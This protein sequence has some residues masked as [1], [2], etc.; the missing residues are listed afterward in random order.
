MSV[1]IDKLYEE[2]LFSQ[3]RV[4]TEKVGGSGTI[5]YSAPSENTKIYSTYVI[6]CHHII[7][8]A[9]SVRKD[10]D[11]KLGREKK[12]EFRQLVTTEFFDWS[13][14][15]HG[16]R[17][18]NYSTDA[19]ILAY[20]KD[21]DMALLKLRTVKTASYVAEILHPDYV[22]GLRVGHPVWA[23]GAALLH[24]PILTDGIITHMGDDIDF[25]YYWMSNAPIIF[26]NSGGAVFAETSNGY[27]FIGIPS[28]VAIVGWSSVV[29]HIGYF[30]PVTRVYEFFRE[31]LFDFLIP[32]SKE[33]EASCEIKR[34]DRAEREEKKALVEEE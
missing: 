30:S 27:K 23:V 4:K 6:T 2:V 18:V 17:P 14:V 29:T 13:N 10:W 1:D 16:S 26:G 11:S 8:S 15:P 32:G 20:D 21:H 33:T 22:E 34:K 31:Q 28:R 9:L 5:I 25:K 12:R 3:V 24:D 7:S 19:E